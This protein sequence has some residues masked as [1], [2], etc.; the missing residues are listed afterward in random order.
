MKKIDYLPI[1]SFKDLSKDWQ[2]LEHGQEMTYFQTFNWF[3]SFL[4]VIPKD[5]AN[6]ESRF[7]IL[8]TDG[9]VRII[10]PLW[11]V[12]RDFYKV[13]EAGIYLLGRGGWSDY[14]NFIY[15]DASDEDFAFLLKDVS[16]H[17]GVHSFYFEDVPDSSSLYHSIHQH[18]HLAYEQKIICLEVQL[19]SD[20]DEYHSSLSKHTRQ[21][22]RTSE[23]RLEKDG[24]TI[25][26]NL[27]D[28]NIDKSLCRKMRADRLA[29]KKERHGLVLT[30]KLR[31][32]NMLR[33]RFKYG[34]PFDV[35]SQSHLMSAYINGELAAYFNY[36]VDHAH[37]RI[38]I[39]A[40]GT[41]QKYAWYSP[42][43]LLAYR[44]IQEQIID[45]KVE[46]VD[47]TRGN[48]KYKYSLG[49]Q[50]HYNCH[51]KFSV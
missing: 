20:V 15:D 44:F 8:K 47:F 9:Q 51:L 30:L 48:E 5:T 29:P 24:L 19:P 34:I 17:Y 26:F 42:G 27:N 14:L 11:I 12:K 45:G 3:S 22:L 10:A 13:N 18:C 39:M 40:A 31:F 43:M 41:S 33:V 36:G 2:R 6:Y 49:G 4:S 21:N 32:F 16:A 25:A 35:D 46:T 28:I 38:V 50:E 1:S 23:N 37:K 7:A